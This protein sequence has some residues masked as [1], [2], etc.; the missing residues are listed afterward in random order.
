MTEQKKLIINMWSGPR[1]I[2]T[3]MMRAW[4][5][6]PDTVV[7]DEPFYGYYLAKT[8]KVHPM[9]EETIAAQG[10]DGNAVINAMNNL[11]FTPKTGN[12]SGVDVFYQKQMCHHILPEL[13]TSWLSIPKHC[14]LIR[15]PEDVINSYGKRMDEMALED[16]GFI[17]QAALFDK[18]CDLQ[19]KAPLVVNSVDVLK[20]PE[21]ILSAICHA[22]EIPFY[23]EMLSWPAGE[24]ASDGAWADH[25]YANVRKT[26]GF[27]S[28]QEKQVH[29]D[30]NYK[31]IADAAM[32]YYE[33]LVPYA[34]SID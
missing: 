5:N 8:G 28:Y 13:D 25:W 27:N 24:R 16:I 31:G 21:A 9:A 6:R 30:E 2:S 1:N 14:F 17:Q 3:A 33:K 22:F 7:V 12:N 10:A 26:T 29:L 4:E 15:S 34:L 19:G 23:Q 18:I 11:N 32:P 20:N